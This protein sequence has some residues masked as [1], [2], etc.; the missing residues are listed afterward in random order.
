MLYFCENLTPPD[1]INSPGRKSSVCVEDEPSIVSPYFDSNDDA[2]EMG[3]A[4]ENS[5]ALAGGQDL[6][7]TYKKTRGIGG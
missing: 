7:I 4:N 2:A 3:K 5:L 6:S 1:S